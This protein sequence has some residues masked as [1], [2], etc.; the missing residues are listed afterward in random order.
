MQIG[1]L[2]RHENDHYDT[3]GIVTENSRAAKNGEKYTMVTVRWLDDM[4]TGIYWTDELE[5]ICK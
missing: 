2:V 4:G 5:V 1:T 3:I